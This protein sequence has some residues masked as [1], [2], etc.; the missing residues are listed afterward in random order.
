MGL[1]LEEIFHFEA[2]NAE[3]R[4]EKNFSAVEWQ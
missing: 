1:A 3:K 2:K 4:D